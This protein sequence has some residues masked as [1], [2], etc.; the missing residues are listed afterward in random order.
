MELTLFGYGKAQWELWGFL[1]NWFGAIGSISAAL[2]A[3]YIAHRGTL[4][5]ARVSVQA[6]SDFTEEYVT[7][8]VAN[9]GDRNFSVVQIGWKTGWLFWR[10][11]YF[12]RSL[13][14]P[15]LPFNLAHG[16]TGQWK[17]A[18]RKPE[19]RAWYQA[20]ASDLGERY[21]WALYTL[22]AQIFTSNGRVFSVKP[23]V[24]I[25]RA[26]RKRAEAQSRSQAES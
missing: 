18:T 2:A 8:K 25:L 5:R 10:R 12:E 17:L 4:P 1:A 21:V 7:F 16:E 6:G 11:T 20:F 23:E 15:N 14:G 24:G 19:Q 9:I 3:L 22:R 13:S 26:L